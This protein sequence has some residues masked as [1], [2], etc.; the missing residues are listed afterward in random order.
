MNFK[1]FILANI[2]NINAC[3]VATLNNDG[4]IMFINDVGRDK[5]FDWIM[6]LAINLVSALTIQFRI[7]ISKDFFM[8]KPY[9]NKNNR[10]V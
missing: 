9:N 10:I 1:L 7:N 2:F 8:Y 6:V 3:E 4:K 5:V